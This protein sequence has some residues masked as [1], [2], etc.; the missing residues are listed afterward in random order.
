MALET[1]HNGKELRW[2]DRMNR[3]SNYRFEISNL[4]FF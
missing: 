3:I 4:K 2:M 1:P